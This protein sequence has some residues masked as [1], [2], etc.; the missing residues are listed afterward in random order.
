MFD[1]NVTVTLVTCMKSKISDWRTAAWFLKPFK[2]KVEAII[3][4]LVKPNSTKN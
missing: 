2:E 3:Y 1:I 4:D